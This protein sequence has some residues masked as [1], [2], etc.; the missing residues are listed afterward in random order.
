[1]NLSQT[2]LKE[3]LDY[4]PATGIFRWRV[5]TN[6]RIRIGEVAGSIHVKGHRV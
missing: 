3:L 1:M 2:R 4:N 5:A 6:G